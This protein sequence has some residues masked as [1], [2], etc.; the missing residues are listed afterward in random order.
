MKKLAYLTLGL[1]IFLLPAWGWSESKISLN[2]VEAANECRTQIKEVYATNQDI[3]FMARPAS[4]L[5]KGT[6]KFWINATVSDESGRESRRYMCEITR[7]GDLLEILQ[8][9]GRW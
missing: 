4:S 6:Y 3:R 5:S 1:G 8:E 7:E 9:D 2:G